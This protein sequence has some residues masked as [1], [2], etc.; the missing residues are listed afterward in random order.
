MATVAAA[1]S[2]SHHNVVKFTWTSLTTFDSDPGVGVTEAWDDGAQ[3]PP[4]WAEYVDRN[5]QV[6]G[7]LGADFNL[8]IEGGRDGETFATLNDAV[9]TAIAFTAAGIK[10]IQETTPYM[11]PRITDGEIDV[12]DVTVIITARRDRG[13][14]GI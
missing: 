13:G 12:T 11:R 7:T 5:V 6:L 10:Q 2:F 4:N 1:V 9:G 14:Q 3:I 8:V